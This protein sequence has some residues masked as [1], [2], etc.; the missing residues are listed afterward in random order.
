MRAAGKLRRGTLVK[1]AAV[2]VL[3]AVLL[4]GPAVPGARGGEGGPRL[5]EAIPRG[6]AL[7]RDAA[8]ALCF[9]RPMDLE[10]LAAAVAFEPEV[11][12]E[13]SGESACLVTP[14][15][16]LEGG[17]EYAFRL[18][19]GVARDLRGRR[20][21]DGASF[22]FT[23]RDD[24][25]TLEV[26]ALSFMGEV[27]EGNDPDW[28]AALLGFGVGQYPGAGRP[29][30]GNLVLMAHASGQIGF[31]FNRLV[32]LQE[33]DVLILRYGGRSFTYAWDDGR[34][35]AET[36]VSI[37]DPSPNPRLTIFICCG[38]D[39]RPSPTFHPPYRYVMGAA[40]AATQPK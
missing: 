11:E 31:P 37:L 12:F 19:P 18:E 9:D 13:V 28:V 34:V 25:M 22:S 15:N 27:L 7:G 33:G 5:L 10:S 30:R 26:P 21:E 3:A 35:V 29:G 16:L 24:A 1:A 23:T 32:E 17:R 40:L 2:V 14:V 8:V 6:G 4:A 20:C 36:E 38:P 39:G